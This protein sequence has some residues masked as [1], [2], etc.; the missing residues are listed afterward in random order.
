MEPSAWRE[1]S[2]EDVEQNFT[3]GLWNQEAWIHNALPYILA[4]GTQNDLSSLSLGFLIYKMGC[5]YRSAIH[6]AT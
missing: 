6:T 5:Y 1:S 2:P 4:V 3:R